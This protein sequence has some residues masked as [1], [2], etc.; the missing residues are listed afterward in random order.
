MT[1][2][3]NY[4]LHGDVPEKGTICSCLTAQEPLTSKMIQDLFPYQGIFH[5]RV[6]MNSP[7]VLG[8]NSRDTEETVGGFGSFLWMDLY[9]DHDSEIPC[10]S[11]R[12]LDIQ[13]LVLSL[14]QDNEAEGDGETNAA[15]SC[16]EMNEIFNEIGLNVENRPFR[17]QI[18][19][20]VLIVREGEGDEDEQLSFATAANAAMN[21]AQNLQNI[22]LTS[23]T[24]NV[25]SLWGAMKSTAT[26]FGMQLSTPTDNLNKISTHFTTAYDDSI[27]RHVVVLQELW[28][29]L[30][31]GE[32]PLP[33]LL[34][35]HP[36]LPCLLCPFPGCP[37][38][39]E[40]PKWR[41]AGFQKVDPT[42]DVKNTG[43]LALRCMRYLGQTYPE[44]TQRMVTS[45]KENI[46]THYPFAVVGINL[47]L[48]LVDLLGV[49]D[50]RCLPLLSS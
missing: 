37:F 6:K 47:T 18:D 39:R 3:V 26:Q 24:K 34:I 22:T 31:P 50:K 2:Q 42:N 12:I 36:P 23:V 35:S 10:P 29:V 27:H 45:Q 48:L 16:R 44:E 4:H 7:P 43:M 46:K 19:P 32:L 14:P 5:F 8:R 20:E 13:V 21:I 9:C 40:S 38:E 11:D 17:K 49:K 41:E 25:G 30:F 28:Q 15:D 33:C 1:V